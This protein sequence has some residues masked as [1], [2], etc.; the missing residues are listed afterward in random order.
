[1]DRSLYYAQ[2]AQQREGNPSGSYS[3]ASSGLK[4]LPTHSKS[5]SLSDPAPY[6]YDKTHARQRSTLEKPQD[7]V[8]VVVIGPSQNGKSTFI[9]KLRS[10]AADPGSEAKTGDGAERCTVDCRVYPLDLPMTRWRLVDTVTSGGIDI[11]E[12]EATIFEQ[13]WKRKETRIIP[14]D[15]HCP[16]MQ[17]RIIDTPGLDD[18]KG[19]D[20]SHIEKV[21]KKLCEMSE[22]QDPSERYINTLVYVSNY[23]T[24]FSRGFQDTFRHYKKCMP[25]LF[26]SLVIVNTHFA[27]SKWEESYNTLASNLG[28]LSRRKESAKTHVMKQRRTDFANHLKCDPRHFYLDSKPRE[29]F[30]FEELTTRNT[31][32]EILDFFACQGQMPITQM[33]LFKFPKMVSIDFKLVDYLN[34]AKNYWQK[35][36]D[37]LM[38]HAS[39]AEIRRTKLAKRSLEWE[40]DILRWQK[41]IDRWDT[42][43]H[44]A[45]NTYDTHDDISKPNRAWK[46]VTFQKYKNT[47]TFT[48]KVWPFFVTK[49][50]SKV[51]H[52]TSCYFTDET[53]T[54]TGSYK[55]DYAKVP[56]LN[57]ASF[58]YNRHYY[59][60]QLQ[61]LQDRKRKHEVL[62]AENHGFL[63][64]A[65]ADV[66]A[67]TDDP[68]L[69]QLGRWI[70][71]CENIV[72]ALSAEEVPLADGFNAAG[73]ERYKKQVRD[74][75]R[76][77][78]YHMVRT[79][80]R[81]EGFDEALL[82][83]QHMFPG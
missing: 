30:P 15:E 75:G 77:D 37:S 17:L 43:T 3:H 9:N 51:A 12:D 36:Q 19:E 83:I 13:L 50:D 1:M 72:K 25:N 81:S 32:S 40:A 23:K 46:I 61:D 65:E 20:A 49:Q 54:W 76:R 26:G 10:L 45:L 52:W 5:S 41:D 21:L 70:N 63:Q 47:L 31:I 29:R 2:V 39:A 4:R 53:K 18:S 8:N 66:T 35:Q 6:D 28:A 14:T 22:S 38:T 74:I 73:R 55:A 80:K 62:L 78:L 27:V 34:N 82:A 56:L 68:R 79:E 60:D 69:Q 33:R 44:Y 11:P 71:D 64:D 42:D 58:T 7:P 16:R 48:E 67:E 57:V 59:A 24:A